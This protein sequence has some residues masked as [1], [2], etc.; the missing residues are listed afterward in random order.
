MLEFEKKQFMKREQF[1]RVLIRSALVI[2]LGI[3]TWIAGR[4]T[5]SGSECLQCP[6]KSICNENCYVSCEKK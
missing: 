4:K 5:V 2:I 6:L 1:I 3:I